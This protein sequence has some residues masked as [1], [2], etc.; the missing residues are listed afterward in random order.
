[1][2][3]EKILKRPDGSRVKIEVC[4]VTDWTRDDQN[5]RF[6][7]YHCPPRKRSWTSAINTDDYSWRKLDQAG[8]DVENRRRSLTLAT[9]TEVAEAMRELIKKLAPVV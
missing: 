2:R 7:C 3:H 4:L 8:R 1:M 6:E 9:E 5:W